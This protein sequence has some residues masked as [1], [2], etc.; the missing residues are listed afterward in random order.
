LLEDQILSEE[1]E[2][3]AMDEP[4]SCLACVKL[5]LL[6]ISFSL[7]GDIFSSHLVWLARFKFSLIALVYA[8]D[9]V[10]S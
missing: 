9:K 7:I 4:R 8:C 5:K 2:E 10:T 1:D 6:L 3:L